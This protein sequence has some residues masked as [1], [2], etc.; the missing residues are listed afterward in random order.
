MKTTK[1]TTR[2]PDYSRVVRSSQQ[3]LHEQ[4]FE[5]YRVGLGRFSLYPGTMSGL[6]YHV[7]VLRLLLP[8]THT[9]H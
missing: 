6:T 8:D 4:S 5:V 2:E 9:D 7:Y 1:L 3:C